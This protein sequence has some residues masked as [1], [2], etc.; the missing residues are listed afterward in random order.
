MGEALRACVSRL[1]PGDRWMI[2]RC[3]FAPAPPMGDSWGKTRCCGGQRFYN[4]RRATARASGH[5][6]STIS[7]VWHMRKSNEGT[8]SCDPLGCRRT[9]NWDR[10]ALCRKTQ[11]GKLMK[12]RSKTFCDSRLFPR[13]RS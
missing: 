9:R 7:G 1:S 13:P 3:R 11:K 12:R 8:T 6:R 10:P 4:R 5:A 2:T